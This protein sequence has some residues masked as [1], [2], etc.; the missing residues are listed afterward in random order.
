MTYNRPGTPKISGG[1]SAVVT[2]S[3]APATPRDEARMLARRTGAGLD[4]WWLDQA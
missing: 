3:N 4:R 1:R 2:A